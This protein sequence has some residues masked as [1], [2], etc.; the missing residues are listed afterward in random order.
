MEL[1]RGI[2]I[3]GNKKNKNEPEIRFKG[4]YN[5]K[6]EWVAFTDAW[7]QKKF[8]KTFNYS[9]GM[10]VPVEN[11]SFDKCDDKEQFIRI[12]DVTQESEPP[13]YVYNS[14]GKGHVEKDDIFFVR[15]GAIGAVGIG[16][17][18]TI[19]NNLFKILPKHTIDSQ[20]MYQQFANGQFNNMLKNLS[21]S[22]SMPAINFSALNNL[23]YYEPSLEE[24]KKIGVYFSS[25]DR[26]IT[27]QQRKLDEYKEFKKCMLQKMFPRDGKKVPEIRFAGFTG[28]WE[29]KKV[30]D[31]AT[32]L[33]GNGLNWNDIDDNGKQECILYGNLYTDYGMIAD[34]VI[35]KTNVQ[36]R[37]PVFSKYGDVLIPASDTTPTGLARATGLLK[38][39]VLLGGDINIIRPNKGINGCCL[40]LVLNANKQKLLP[41]IKGT[42]VRHLHT[43][44]IKDVVVCFPE[45]EDEQAKIGDYFKGLDNFIT[46]QQQK[47]DKYKLL[48]KCMLQKMFC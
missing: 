35:Y 11:Q 5:E 30:E 31:Y 21:A 38:S 13:R 43:S 37:N 40:S 28:D 29:Q 25:L 46:I 26:F 20:F 2:K 34:K 47:L 45:S 6:G 24:Q 44:E 14:T 23:V 32:L 15:Y 4:A 19:A 48:K 41:L 36:L 22:T 18:G 12:V 17:T 39:D 33:T 8:S 1:G 3:M 7:E 16:Y 27:L 9:Q 10:Q 42:T